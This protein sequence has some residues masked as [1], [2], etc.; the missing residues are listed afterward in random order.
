MLFFPPNDK[1]NYTITLIDTIITQI[2]DL[3]IKNGM[4]VKSEYPEYDVFSNNFHTT[5]CTMKCVQ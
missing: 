4:N 3:L 5:I 1:I 2:S